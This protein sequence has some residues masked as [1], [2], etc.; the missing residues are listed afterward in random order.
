MRAPFAAGNT[1]GFFPYFF[2]AGA[3]GP[4]IKS[5]PGMQT[6][7]LPIGMVIRFPVAPGTADFDIFHTL[8]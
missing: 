1:L 4:G 8:R 2:A 5:I 3:P 7:A 6:G